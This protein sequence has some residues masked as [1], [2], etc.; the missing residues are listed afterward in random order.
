MILFILQINFRKKYLS[1]F[2]TVKNVGMKY[3]W[4]PILTSFLTLSLVALLDAQEKKDSLKI[5]TPKTKE[6]KIFNK[7][8]TIGALLVGDYANSF[9]KEVDMNGKHNPSGANNGFYL[10]YFRVNG[11]FA[12]NDQLS[13]Q[14]L[15][16]FADFKSDP[17]NKVLEIAALKWTPSTY[18]NLQVGQF[19]PYFG[20]E[21][22]YPA[23]IMKSYAW[24]NQY[25]LLGKSNWESFQIGAAVSGSL[26]KKKIPLRYY[27]TFYNGNGKNQLQDNDNSKNHS[28]RLEYDV[29]PKLQLGVNDAATKVEG[30]NANMFG[31]D[32]SYHTK[33]SKLWNAGFNSEFKYGTNVSA[34]TAATLAGKNISDYKMTGFYIIPFISR[35]INENNKSFVE[36]TCRYEYLEDVNKNGNIGRFYTPMLSYVIGDDYT[37][38]ISLVGVISDYSKD[39]INTIQYSSKLLL[40]QYQIRF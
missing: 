13:A 26:I 40:L 37:S 12:I 17:K 18:F 1:T 20:L 2:A 36:F 19:R 10:V 29:L 15:V 4:K 8:A 5:E 14:I 35:T 21:D 9:T 33:L 28:L 25:S 7:K 3:M 27:Y 32:I 30:Q 22:M 16:N 31:A 23:E 39:I 24:S 11:K 38:K 34:F 6:F